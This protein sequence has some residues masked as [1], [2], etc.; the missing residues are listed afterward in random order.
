[1]TSAVGWPVWKAHSPSSTWQLRP[2]RGYVVL[3]WKTRSSNRRRYGPL[4]D[5][6]EYG[7][8]GAKTNTDYVAAGLRITYKLDGNTYTQKL[9]DGSSD[10]VGAVSFSKPSTYKA[11]Y[12]KYCAAIDARANKELVK[13]APTS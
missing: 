10:C 1:M 3:P 8:L 5:M 9:Y 7:V 4:P 12:G 13:T 11:V 6:I 2:L